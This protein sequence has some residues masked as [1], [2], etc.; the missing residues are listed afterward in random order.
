MRQAR[1]IAGVGCFSVLV[2]GAVLVAMNWGRISSNALDLAALFDG[3]ESA[4]ALRSVDALVDFIGVYCSRVS[5]VAYRLDDP[6]SAILVNPDAR[7]PLASTMKILVLAGYAE[8]VDEG[9][10]SP[11]E[12]VPLAA[13]E[14]FFLPGRDGGAHDRAVEV[15]RRRGWLDGS[16]AV[17]LRDVVW[18]MMAVSDNAATDYLLHRL[19]R[20]RASTLPGRLG[21]AGS[22]P[23]LP[24][25]GVFLSWASEAEGPL[26][27]V[28][29]GLADRLYSDLEFR[30]V[31]SVTG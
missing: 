18:A 11:W 8:A 25:S 31:S 30:M 2:A 21:L 24:I 6:E 20:E 9:R 19:G 14:I 7:R 13:V 27:D 22:D 5:L 26:A 29:W 3:V 15:Y 23:P 12:R 17:A 16:G 28:A 1:R 4:A 10:W